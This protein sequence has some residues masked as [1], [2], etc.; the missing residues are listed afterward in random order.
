M[1]GRF[2]SFSPLPYSPPRGRLFAKYQ[3]G[4]LPLPLL[5]GSI[6]LLSFPALCQV[7]GQ[8]NTLEIFYE[9]IGLHWLYLRFVFNVSRTTF[10]LLPIRYVNTGTTLIIYEIYQIKSSIILKIGQ[11]GFE[12][13][14][15]WSRTKRATNCATA[16]YINAPARV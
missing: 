1:A 12:P 4:F 2:L 8:K 10:Y 15:S 7:P 11:G 14:T 16:R 5:G 9:N 13:P 3:C 6:N